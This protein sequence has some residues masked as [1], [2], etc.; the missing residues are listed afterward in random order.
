MSVLE[1]GVTWVSLQAGITSCII[2][3]HITKHK[4]YSYCYDNLFGMYV[5]SKLLASDPTSK[6]E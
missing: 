3:T 2:G 5:P 1:F 6:E 4:Y